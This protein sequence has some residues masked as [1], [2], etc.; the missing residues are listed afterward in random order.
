MPEMNGPQ[1]VAAAQSVIVYIVLGILYESYI[2]PVTILSTLPSAGVG[3]LLALMFC[4]MLGTVGLPH[5]LTRFYTTP[6]VAETRSSVAWSLF[7]IALL[8]LS[9]PALAVLAKFEIYTV[10]VNAPFDRLPEWIA[11]WSTV[12]KTLVSAV[13]MNKDGIL[14]LAELALGGDIIVLATPEIGGMLELAF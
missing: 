2:H 3:A 13:D 4:L 7:F 11:R 1:L 8:Y 12:D 10:L 14:Q 6:S 5:L 9:A